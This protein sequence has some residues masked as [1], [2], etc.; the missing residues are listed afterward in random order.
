MTQRLMTML[1]ITA[2]VTGKEIAPLRSRRSQIK[3]RCLLQKG[4]ALTIIARV[5]N[6]DRRKPALRTEKGLIAIMHRQA[7]PREFNESANL[8]ARRPVRSNNSITPA[9]TTEALKEA[10]NIMKKMNM[11]IEV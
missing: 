3:Y 9:L 8:S 11:H 10:K 1:S 4:T 5:E 7:K 6:T 2:F